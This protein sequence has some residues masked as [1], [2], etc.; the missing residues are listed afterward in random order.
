M[1]L[2]Y[3]YCPQLSYTNELF[4]KVILQDVPGDYFS[5]MTVV[6]CIVIYNL[7]IFIF[8]PHHTKVAGYYGFTLDVCVGKFRQILTELSAQDTPIFLFPDDNFSKHKWIF[9]KLGMCIDTMEVWFGIA[10]VQNVKF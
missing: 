3:G 2:L 9:T 5:L 7:Q 8:I 4:I 6:P 10:N 1:A